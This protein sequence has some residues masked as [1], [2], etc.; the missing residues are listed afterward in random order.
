MR[1]PKL[2]GL[3]FVDKFGTYFLILLLLV[4]G[5]NVSGKFLSA[6]NLLN[7]LDA[8][9]YLGILACGMALVTY[10]GQLVDL[11]T[12]S[13]VAVAS[14]VAVLTLNW[15][16]VPMILCVLLAGALLGLINGLVVGILRI[17]TVVWTLA[18]SF[19]FAGLI[20]VV[21]GSANIY[22]TEGNLHFFEQ[23]SRYRVLG[24]LPISVIVMLVLMISLHILVSYSRFG[25]Q[26]KM[27]GC[28]ETAAKYGGIDVFRVI[29]FSF[30]GSGVAA[31]I[32][33]LFIASLSKSACY[34]YGGGYEFRAITAVV[35]S[36]MVLD[37]G[38]GSI[39]GVLGG[40]LAIGLMN[41]IMTLCGLNTFLQNVVTGTV[42][43]LV[44]WLTKYTTK[45]L[46]AANG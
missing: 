26:M 18:M 14:F 24:V 29:C 43:I 42:F 25:R 6:S 8:V 15:G 28:S 27:V 2:K 19:V 16:T 46:E 5:I 7:I 40:V 35:L 30:V 1:M 17:N 45:K 10:C 23:I 12:P 21:F 41:N 9:S 22:P 11:S 4:I 20:R 36:G 33:G 3:G 34:N 44:V 13:T 32:T 39:L 38:K 31:A 37:G